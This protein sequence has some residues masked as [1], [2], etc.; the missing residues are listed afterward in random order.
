MNKLVFRDRHAWFRERS[1]E[2]ALRRELDAALAPGGDGIA[3]TD[4]V[5]L[6]TRSLVVLVAAMIGLDGAQTPE[7]I[8]ELV[9]LQ[10]QLEE[11]PRLRTQMGVLAPPHDEARRARALAKLEEA[12]AKFTERFYA[13]ALARRARL[14]ERNRAGEIDESDLPLDFL[15]LVAGHADP[16]FGEDADLAV[17]HAVIDLLHAGVGTTVG[18]IVQTVDELLRWFAAHPEDRALATDPAFLR[19]AVHEV[20]RLHSANPAEVRFAIAD[21]TLSGG[22]VIRAG[23]YAAL[24][25]GLADRDPAV[26]G[27]DADRFDP[28][29]VTP[30]ATYPHG[31]AFGSGP[32]MC[33][34]M[35]LVIGND[36]T[37]GNVVLFA[38]A[39]FEAGVEPDP[40]RTPS[41][42][43]AT[44]HADLKSFTTYP[45]RF[46]RE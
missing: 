40:E 35:P 38:R 2:P 46:A 43:P 7:G 45:V 6:S 26:F 27:A 30:P 12:K 20:L 4:L 37:D 15:M 24:R 3:R 42:E 29:R 13:P 25:T 10:A 32:H 31:V 44:A 1:L 11:F 39:L 5:T 21:T 18:A 9:A 33:Y 23:Q 41:Y 34:G 16:A 8:A 22:T 36:G 19:G 17:R 28:R 14:L